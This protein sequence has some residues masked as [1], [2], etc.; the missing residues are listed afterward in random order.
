MSIE[1]V[2]NS[3][4]PDSTPL[5]P[6]A[7]EAFDRFAQLVR[8][9]LDVPVALVSL[10]DINQ[11]VFPGASGL[12]AD[13]DEARSTPLSHSFCQH[14]VTSA[15]PLVI[16][17]ARLDALVSDNPAVRDLAVVAYAGM[18][19]T[20]TSGRVIGSLCAIDHEPRAWTASELALLADLAAACS[21]ELHVREFASRAAEAY[22]RTRVLVELSQ[23][24]AAATTIAEVSDAVA[25]LSTRRLGASY[26]ALALLD[27]SGQRLSYRDAPF[28]PVV[29]QAGYSVDA[30][31]LSGV[32]VRSRM[33]Q[34]SRNLVELARYGPSAVPAAEAAGAQSVACVPLLVGS[35]VL[36][37]LTLF[38]AQA[39]RPDGDDQAIVLSLAGYA[40][41]AVH[42]AELLAGRRTA[43]RILQDALMPSL[44]EAPGFEL[45]GRYEP[46]HE[47]DQVGGDWYDAFVPA[48]GENGMLT[49]SVGDVAGHD[50]AA[51]AVMG[52]VRASLRA[53]L[54]DRPGRPGIVLERLDRVL[55]TERSARLVTAIVATFAPCSGGTQV[56]WSNAGHLP[57]LL[58]TPGQEPRFLRAEPNPM[59]GLGPA[60]TRGEHTAFVPA[61]ATVLLFTDGLVERRDESIE[62]S[63]DA[64][65]RMVGA[66]GDLPLDELLDRIIGTSLARGHDD[67]TALFGIRVR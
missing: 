1:P 38:W 63:L 3:K 65:A 13:V 33:P 20:D 36:G 29:A 47:S 15:G 24:L 53:L 22:S 12:P 35:Q 59:L 64:L 37:T 41:Q 26:A 49:V 16:P 4:L 43:A 18:P 39:D 9:V 55:T 28:L 32:A 67:D 66:L 60:W 7:D 62:D 58:V 10:V 31:T 23:S 11:Q 44:P 27:E 52:Q 57:P 34:F 48:E 50:T 54:I 51:A 14:V 19:L 42:R 5:P 61:G 45:A 8:K 6:V 21:S 56:T 46:A 2:S 30:A 17:D 40:A 25:E